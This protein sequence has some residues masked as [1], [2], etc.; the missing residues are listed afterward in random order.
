MNEFFLAV[1]DINLIN[2]FLLSVDDFSLN[3]ISFIPKDFKGKVAITFEDTKKLQD[4]FSYSSISKAKVIFDSK[5]T[6]FS[7]LNIVIDEKKGAVSL[8]K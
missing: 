4:S 7:E 8:K 2:S 5:V 6:A 1:D 3:P